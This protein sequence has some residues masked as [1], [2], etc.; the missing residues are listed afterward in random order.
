MRAVVQQV[1]AAVV[2][3]VAVLA[4]AS[5]TV[6]SDPRPELPG[7]T[8]TSSEGVDLG[9]DA[10]ADPS[11]P[12][13]DPA[14]LPP[15]P[16]LPALIA[17]ASDPV[18]LAAEL[19][20][21]TADDAADPVA[22]WLA[23]YDTVG[24]PVPGALAGGAAP[25]GVEDPM[26]PR[27]DFVWSVG[28][29]S[30]GGAAS[31]LTDAA[32]ALSPDLASPIPPDVFLS[33]IRAAASGTDARSAMLARFVAG[34][35]VASGGAD[36]LDPAATADAV[37]VDAATVQLLSWIF[38]R[39]AL[40]GVVAESG[41]ADGATDAAGATEAAF[42]DG[43]LV[44]VVN[45]ATPPASPCATAWGSE[46]A[47]SWVNWATEKIGGGFTIPG[48]PGF[49]GSV[50]A[51]IGHVLTLTGDAAAEG[52]S[53]LAGTLAERANIAAGL[54]SLLA[55]INSLTVEVSTGGTQLVR[56]REARDGGQ[57]T[58][59]LDLIYDQDLIDGNNEE[60]C[61][62]AWLSAVAGVGV[63][64]PVDGS[65]V[66]LA[67]I[68]ISGGKNFPEKVYFVSASDVAVTTDANGSARIQV[69]GHARQKT[70]SEGAEQVEDE[71]E[72]S[73][74]A[75][76]G[77][78]GLQ[79]M[80]S[81]TIDGLTLNWASAVI[82]ALKAFQYRVP[83]QFLP[84]T[85]WQVQGYRIDHPFGDGFRLVGDVCDLG[86]PFTLDMVGPWS[87]LFSFTPTATDAFSWSF[88]GN[89]GGTSIA[90]S[91]SASVLRGAPSSLVLDSGSFT[92]SL[93]GQ[94]FEAFDTSSAEPAPLLTDAAACSTP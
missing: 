88:A 35:S 76:P 49:S 24:V 87:G 19:V 51:W 27:W 59:T 33:D 60:V 12:V 79:N 92:G 38:L 81:L 26:G 14:D 82:N 16:P 65:G 29:M 54:V 72:L 61:V 22:G 2:A 9:S 53:E 46:E 3:V 45:A 7:A 43:G 15:P 23:V 83:S 58:L 93:A 75:Q 89:A 77:E 21:V 55:Q 10:A 63:T 80:L 94:S 13:F 30:T 70:L 56:N 90:G 5:C 41:I 37:V 20:A 4:V 84:F 68:S 74:R 25:E 62:L 71:Y 57:Q 50:K 86:A 85:D 17:T 8:D 42:R 91:G 11:G 40:V 52:A 28:G 67:K 73:F 6:G 34:K 78:S 48:L 1:R 39:E 36:P 64:I 31:P 66:G 69:Q 44:A 47:T 18:A 32:V